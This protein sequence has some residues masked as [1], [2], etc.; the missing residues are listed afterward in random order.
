MIGHQSAQKFALDDV[1]VD[2]IGNG[3]KDAI[4][5]GDE[6][7]SEMGLQMPSKM[8][9]RLYLKENLNEYQNGVRIWSVSELYL[10]TLNIVNGS[11]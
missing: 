10:K 4:W 3:L 11:C 7:L 6:K 1:V 9:A 2:G 5:R 8:I